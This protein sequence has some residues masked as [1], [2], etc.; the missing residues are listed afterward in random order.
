MAALVDP[1][2]LRLVVVYLPRRVPAVSAEGRVTELLREAEADVRLRAGAADAAAIL[3]LAGVVGVHGLYVEALHPVAECPRRDVVLHTGPVDG[4]ALHD[5][6]EGGLQAVLR[7]LLIAADR[8]GGQQSPATAT[9][10]EASAGGRRGG[11]GG[12]GSGEGR[13]GRGAA[14]QSRQLT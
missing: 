12:E 5:L 7:V 10:L 9:R 14:L 11:E 8:G 4:L 13:E 6:L 3:V 1:Q 2:A